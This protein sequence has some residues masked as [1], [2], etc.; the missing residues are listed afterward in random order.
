MLFIGW[1]LLWKTFFTQAGERLK[2]VD[3]VILSWFI[4]KSRFSVN[5]RSI[6]HVALAVYTRINMA[7]MLRP[8]SFS[9]YCYTII[10]AIRSLVPESKATYN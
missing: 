2:I 9:V 6:C 7:H 8:L 5:R 10:T 1:Q 4:Q 3:I